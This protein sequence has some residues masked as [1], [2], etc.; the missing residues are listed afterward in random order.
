MLVLAP[1]L[2]AAAHGDPVAAFHLHLANT[3]CNQDPHEVGDA[4]EMDMAEM[5]GASD[6]AFSLWCGAHLR[7]AL[8][9]T[10]NRDSSTT[11]THSKS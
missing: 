10:A 1:L 3:A 4:M 8:L 5:R 2:L 7:T 11:A 6:E 9:N